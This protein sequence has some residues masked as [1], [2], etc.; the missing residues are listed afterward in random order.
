MDFPVSTKDIPFRTNRGIASVISNYCHLIIDHA[1][2]LSLEL[3]KYAVLI[4]QSLYAFNTKYN[5]CIERV[6]TLK[7]TADF[8]FSTNKSQIG[9][10]ISHWFKKTAVLD[11]SLRFLSLDNLFWTLANQWTVKTSIT[12]LPRQNHRK[13]LVLSNP[14]I[15]RSQTRMYTSI[16]VL[17]GETD[18]RWTCNT[19]TSPFFS[20]SKVKTQYL[21]T[22]SRIQSVLLLWSA[23]VYFNSSCLAMVTV[24][25]FGLFTPR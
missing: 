13:L 3:S 23:E 15:A 16:R 18:E 20:D 9:L 25:L 7:Q 21:L 24:Q 8:V 2:D 11:S 1:Y 6:Q 5:F 19:Y 10:M 4:I 12:T 14:F 17:W 22:N